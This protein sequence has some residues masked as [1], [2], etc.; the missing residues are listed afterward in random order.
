MSGNQV[1]VSAYISEGTRRLLE[2]MTEARGLK[3]GYVIEEALIH[4]LHAMQEMPADLLIPGR[5]VLTEASYQMVEE[6]LEQEGE[7][8]PA[9]RQL[10]GGEAVDGDPF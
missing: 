1:Q 8:T 6:L 5:I 2:E 9:M 7:A 3:K 10:M 4:Y